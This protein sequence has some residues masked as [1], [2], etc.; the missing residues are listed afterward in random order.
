[1]GKQISLGGETVKGIRTKYNFVG[2]E[3]VGDF[4]IVPL[5][6]VTSSMGALRVLANIRGKELDRKF[7]CHKMFDGSQKVVRKS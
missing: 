7:G 2:L 1:M 6:D 3:E 4:F 5:K